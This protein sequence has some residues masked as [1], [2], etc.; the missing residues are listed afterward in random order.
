MRLEKLAR[1]V[2]TNSLQCQSNGI[3]L[4]LRSRGVIVLLQTEEVTDV[5]GMPKI[6]EISKNLQY[7]S[8]QEIIIKMI[9]NAMHL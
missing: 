9:T 7:S 1:T 8:Q 5:K 2:V 6:K 4:N 3:S